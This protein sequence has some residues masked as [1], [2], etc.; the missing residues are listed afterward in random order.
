MWGPC[1]KEALTP[2]AA[3]AKGS[4]RAPKLNILL[5]M[6]E[7]LIESEGETRKAVIIPRYTERPVNNIHS[8]PATNQINKTLPNL[9]K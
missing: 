9:S 2:K 6:R 5:Q 7:S 8:S 4:R 1:K 3:T